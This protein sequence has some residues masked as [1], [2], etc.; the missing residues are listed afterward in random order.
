MVK[1]STLSQSAMQESTNEEATAGAAEDFPV[2][3]DTCLGPNPYVRMIKIPLGKECPITG[4]PFTVFK[5]KPGNEARYKSAVISKEAALMKNVCQ[6]CLFD[7]DYQLPIGVVEQLGGG[8][9][10]AAGGESGALAIPQS[11]ANREFFVEQK[12]RNEAEQ[13]KLGTGGPMKNNPALLKMSRANNPYYRRNKAKLCTF[14]LTMR[15]ERVL[16]QQCPYRPC[17]GDFDFPELSM[18]A[19]KKLAGWI[20]EEGVAKVM[21]RNDEE[22]KEMR[23]QLGGAIRGNVDQQIK[24]RYHGVNDALASKIIKGVG[25][26]KLEPL[27]PPDDETITTLFVG[28]VPEEVSEQDLKD[29]MYIHGE[30]ASVRI[31]REK[32]CAFVTF[33]DRQGAEKAAQELAHKLVVKGFYLKLMWGRPRAP[34]ADP[35]L[36]SH[37]QGAA[38]AAFAPRVMQL[39]PGAPGAPMMPPPGMMPPLG[40]MPP[41]MMPPPG[42]AAPRYYPSMNP[43][44]MGTRRPG[45]EQPPPRNEE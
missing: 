2:I 13:L 41:G 10:A 12:F 34:R 45:A 18:E 6:V 21:V 26:E 27:T 37:M 15:C 25:E 23:E 29:A 36:P 11:D 4:R 14:W 16:N 35:M 9:A 30:I 33:S 44:A 43:Q 32:K 5:F 40:M 38:A 7:L 28:G 20:E 8:E 3:C 42:M 24:N 22:M 39:P 1:L 31:I 17:N 19:S